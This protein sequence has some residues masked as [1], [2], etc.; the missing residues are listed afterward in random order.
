MKPDRTTGTRRSIYLA[1]LGTMLALSGCGLNERLRSFLQGDRNSAPVVRVADAD[2]TRSEL[3]YFFDS[4][5]KVKEF[6]WEKVGQSILE[7][8]PESGT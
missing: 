6:E 7:C 8:N 1:C 4:R 5:Q 3:E 2:Y